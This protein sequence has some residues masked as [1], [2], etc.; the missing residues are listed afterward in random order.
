MKFAAIN[1]LSIHYRYI[2]AGI[3]KPLIVFSNSL[4]TDFRIWQDCVDDLAGDFSIL[5]YDKRGHGLSSLGNPPYVIDDHVNDLIGLMD[6]LGLSGAAIVGL[7]VGGLI[8]QGVCHARPDL[9]SG[10]VLCD[11]AA[12]IGTE[13]M[14]NDRIAIARDGGLA[15]LVDANMQR[16]FSPGFHHGRPTDLGGFVAMFTRTPV[17]AYI[18]TG[19]AIRDAD[20]RSKASSI[21][22]PTICVVGDQDG[23]TPPELVES[24][25]KLI[26]GAKFEVIKDAGHIPCAE[27]PGAV[28]S[29]IRQMMATI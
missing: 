11:T 13:T 24:T 5:L 28:I 12:K 19:M 27:Q 4:A 10:L 18:G 14:W 22:V 17:E 3:G 26:P 1:G 15:A 21:L 9:V 25:A 8:A 7:S 29:I 6:H 23:A 20:F 16:W 2:D